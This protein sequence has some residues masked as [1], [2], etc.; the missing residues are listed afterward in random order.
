[1]FEE[2]KKLNYFSVKGGISTE[3]SPRMIING[4]GLDYN[5]HCKI[6]FGAFL[7]A[8][9]EPSPTNTNESTTID[10]IYLQP[11]EDNM[12]GGHKVLN[13]ATKKIITRR[14][15]TEIPTPNHIVQ[16]VE[17]LAKKDGIKSLKFVT[18]SIAG[19]EQTINTEIDDDE[20]DDEYYY[21]PENDEE[22]N[23]D[24]PITQSEI[25][26]ITGVPA[27]NNIDEEEQDNNENPIEPQPNEQAREIS[28]TESTQL[29]E[30]SETRRSTRE[31]RPV[32][33]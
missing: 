5:K 33:D 23:D 29:S 7:Q 21:E 9:H 4:K 6:P 17:A 28:D 22:L 26:E 2:T 1:M 30:L 3:C 16:L 12:Q 20:E 8:H 25:D 27:E 18:S 10:A 24:E 14:K 19:V 13:L 32:E 31:T 11:V 15:V